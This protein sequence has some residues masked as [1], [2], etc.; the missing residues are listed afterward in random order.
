MC[1]SILRIIKDAKCELVMLYNI[2]VEL[3]K[4]I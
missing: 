3:E 4:I 1:G 2:N